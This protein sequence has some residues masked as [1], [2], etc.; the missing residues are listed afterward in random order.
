MFY[1]SV[2]LNV[3]VGARSSGGTMRNKL[4]NLLYQATINQW[5]ET[6]EGFQKAI[7]LLGIKSRS[8]SW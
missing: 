8:D 4:T 2:T 6:R 1:G 5:P 3:K 7:S